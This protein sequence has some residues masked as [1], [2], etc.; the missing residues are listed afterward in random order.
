MVSPSNRTNDSRTSERTRDKQ[1]LARKRGRWTDGHLTP[2][3][4][5]ED[6]CLVVN[7]EEAARAPD[8]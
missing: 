1:I 3:Y 6:G 2:G 4:G 5:L 7:E 8:L